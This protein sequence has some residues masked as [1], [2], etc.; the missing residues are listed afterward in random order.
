MA[1]CGPDS[2]F[3][4]NLDSA[5]VSDFP[6]ILRDLVFGEAN[7]IDGR[8]VGMMTNGYQESLEVSIGFDITCFNEAGHILS[9]DV[10]FSSDDT[11]GPGE[12]A[13]F[14]FSSFGEPLNCPYFLITGSG[15]SST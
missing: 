11:L 5:D 15:F 10:E 8:V 4:F 9:Q 1:R 12:Q 7:Y 2:I 13:F 6:T 14:Q 3:S